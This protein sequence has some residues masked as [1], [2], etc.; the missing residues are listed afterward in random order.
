MA[1]GYKANRIRVNG[2]GKPKM[3]K[4]ILLTL[5]SG[6][7]VKVIGVSHMYFEEVR[8]SVKFPDKPTY[9]AEIASNTDEKIYQE[10]V[11]DE[12]V[13]NDP[14]NTPEETAEYKAKLSAY[15]EALAAASEEQNN[16]VNRFLFTKGVEIIDIE[17]HLDAWKEEREFLGLGF[18]KKPSELKFAFIADVV[19]KNAVDYAILLDAIMQSTGVPQE[20]MAEARELF[21]DILEEEEP[22][23]SEAK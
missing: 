5:S 12:T 13:V 8:K 4:E 20:K 15:T 3:N 1:K 21:R 11:I 7:Q 6:I 19:I 22:V 9:K 16:R 10:F 17:E 2:N 23:E 14:S 18:P